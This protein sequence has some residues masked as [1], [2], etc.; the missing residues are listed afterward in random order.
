MQLKE[1]M[2]TEVMQLKEQ[3]RELGGAVKKAEA[4][5]D[6][7]DKEVADLKEQLDGQN[8]QLKEVEKAGAKAHEGP[9]QACTQ[10]LAHTH[11]GP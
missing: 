9:Q 5:T 7:D 1:V 3:L 10:R 11:T 2:S 4:D 6:T 8:A